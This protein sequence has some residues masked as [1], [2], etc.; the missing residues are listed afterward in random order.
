MSFDK[1]NFTNH[2]NSSRRCSKRKGVF[3]NFPKFTGKHL[4]NNVTGLRLAT[5]LKKRLWHRCF[6]V[7]CEIFKKTFFA[8][9]PQMT[10]SATTR[11]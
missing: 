9:D 8:E 11:I 1:E 7:K 5:L 10:A 4:F 6:P 3:R 2:R